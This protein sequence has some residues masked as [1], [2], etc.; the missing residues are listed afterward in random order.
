MEKL[1][2]KLTEIADFK[3][4]AMIS[5]KLQIIFDHDLTDRTINYYTLDITVL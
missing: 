3:S 1:G 2:Y 4:F 5:D